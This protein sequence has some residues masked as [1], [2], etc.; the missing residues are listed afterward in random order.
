MRLIKSERF[1]SELKE[2]VDFI[3]NDNP[4]AALTFYDE[5]LEKIEAITD[6]PYRY[7]MRKA[8]YDEDVRELIFRGYTIPFLI[9]RQREQ[10]VI[11]GIFNQNLWE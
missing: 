11:L 10:I 1:V 5:L 9:D 8:L 2:I 4:Y 7:R 3:A 6:N